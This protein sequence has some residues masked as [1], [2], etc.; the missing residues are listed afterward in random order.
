MPQPGAPL[1]KLGFVTIGLFNGQDPGPGHQ[2][3]LEMIGFGTAVITLGE[4][5]EPPKV[6][7]PKPGCRF[8]P[9]CPV[10]TDV[11][12]TATPELLPLGSEQVACHVTQ[13]SPEVKAFT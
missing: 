1:A 11:C 13:A 10:A 7:D 4:R 6:I 3:T 2:E 12:G 8:Q 9:R 5:G